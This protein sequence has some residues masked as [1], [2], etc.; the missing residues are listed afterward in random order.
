MAVRSLAFSSNSNSLITASDD[1][2]INV[3]DV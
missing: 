3:Y 2:R 1:K